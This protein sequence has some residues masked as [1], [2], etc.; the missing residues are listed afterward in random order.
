MFDLIKSLLKECEDLDSGKKWLMLGNPIFYLT[1]ENSTTLIANIDTKVINEIN[2]MLKQYHAND[3]V[4][5]KE[6][7]N[8]L[9][10]LGTHVFTADDVSIRVGVKLWCSNHEEGKLTFGAIE[11][12]NT[13]LVTDMSSLF[14]AQISF[15]ANIASWD[16]SNVQSMHRMFADTWSFNQPLG[17][18]NTKSVT[19]MSHMFH[20]ATKFNQPL[21]YWNVLNVTDCRSMFEEAVSF[22]QDLHLWHV[23]KVMDMSA[24]FRDASLFNQQLSQWKLQANVVVRDIFKGAI[25]FRQEETLEIFSSFGYVDEKPVVVERTLGKRRADD[26]ESTI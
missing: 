14:E 2:A 20:S 25:S 18:W 22:N 24:M 26:M 12:W 15:N 11:D 16:V 10:N 17:I 21:L 23:T 1:V 6:S 7:L 5:V 8:R 13:S 9:S 3:K 19:D 4:I